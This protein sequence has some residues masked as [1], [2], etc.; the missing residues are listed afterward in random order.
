MINYPH[1]ILIIIIIPLLRFVVLNW[2]KVRIF[3]HD[4]W[5]AFLEFYS[6]LYTSAIV[7]PSLKSSFQLCIKCEPIMGAF[8]KLMH[9]EIKVSRKLK[10]TELIMEK[11]CIIALIPEITMDKILEAL[12]KYFGEVL[13]SFSCVRDYCKLE[14]ALEIFCLKLIV[15]KC[16][17]SEVLK[18]T[19]EAFINN[20]LKDQEIRFIYETIMDLNSKLKSYEA[21][22]DG[23]LLRVLLVETCVDTYTLMGKHYCD[24]IKFLQEINA[25]KTGEDIN[26]TFKRGD[27]TLAIILIGQLETMYRSEYGH[28]PY[29]SYIKYAVEEG[30]KTF[31]ILARGNINCLIANEVVLQ[32]TDR[33]QYLEKTNEYHDEIEYNGKKVRVLCVRLT[34]KKQTYNPLKEYFPNHFLRTNDKS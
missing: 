28:E 11:N 16:S 2:E 13:S 17:F 26:L 14:S 32:V 33:E 19:T 25:K 1:V 30:V 10:E 21:K 15:E 29:V 6:N 34:N 20:K 8:S 4:V 9:L 27:I 3:C 5:V 7:N 24:F 18:L 22:L 12:V 23:R 31:Y